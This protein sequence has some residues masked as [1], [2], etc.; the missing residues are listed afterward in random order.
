MKTS[1][2]VKSEVLPDIFQ[3][4]A[5]YKTP[6]NIREQFE[7]YL[8]R[9][10]EGYEDANGKHHRPKVPNH[11]GLCFHLKIIPSEWEKLKQHPLLGIAIIWLDAVLEDEWTQFL[12][13]KNSAGAIKYLQA[14]YPQMYGDTSD[15]NISISFSKELATMR[16]TYKSLLVKTDIRDAVVL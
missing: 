1:L 16:E 11:A 7:K 6:E 9:C 10:V 3:S 5:I 14:H 15:I 13:T 2:E 8:V 4:P 12:P